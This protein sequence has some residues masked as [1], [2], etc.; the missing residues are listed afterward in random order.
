MN[1]PNF[2]GAS[3]GCAGI[4]DCRSGVYGRAEAKKSASRTKGKIM[5]CS[6]RN[7]AMMVLRAHMSAVHDALRPVPSR[8]RRLVRQELRRADR[9]A[10]RSLAGDQGRPA[11]ADR[12]ADGL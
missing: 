6:A 9:A 8:G 7:H 11:C 10:A 12:G 1:M 4:R 2:M 5:F 3:I